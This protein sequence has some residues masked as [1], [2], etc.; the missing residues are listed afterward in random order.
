MSYRK[1]LIRIT[2]HLIFLLKFGSDNDN[3]TIDFHYQTANIVKYR[4]DVTFGWLDLLVSFGGKINFSKNFIQS[5][6]PLKGI[7]GLFLGCSILSFVE[8]FYYITIIVLM[9]GKRI[10]KKFQKFFDS[11]SLEVRNQKMFKKKPEHFPVV[12]IQSLSVIQDTLNDKI[13]NKYRKR[14]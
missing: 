12:K 3:L 4:T 14:F 2:V 1:F 10:Q 6:F 9:I 13:R 7:A 5:I 8:I 11:Q